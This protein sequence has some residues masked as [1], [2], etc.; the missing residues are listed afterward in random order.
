M[1]LGSI[2]EIRNDAIL[3]WNIKGMKELQRWNNL[4]NQ[5]VNHYDLEEKYYKDDEYVDLFYELQF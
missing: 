4:R 5:I 1:E 3:H 2:P